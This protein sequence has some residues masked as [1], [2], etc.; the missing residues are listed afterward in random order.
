VVGGTRLVCGEY[1]RTEKATIY[2][3]PPKPVPIY[4]AAAGPVVAKLAGERG[5]GLICTS[6]KDP[7]PYRETLLPNLEVGLAKAGRTDESIERMIEMKVSFDTDCARAL[8]DTHY[9]G[10]LALEPEEKLNVED[11]IEM[12]RLADAL[13]VER[14]ASR[15]LVSSDGEEHVEQ[16]RPYVEM[17]FTH[18]VFHART[19]SAALPE[20]LCRASATLATAT[21]RLTVNWHSTCSVKCA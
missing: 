19:R 15:W 10:A 18:P 20:T 21:V 12:E 9:W 4:I 8:S 3:K 13:S 16:I 1:Y 14:A 7:V 5:D 2:D 17:G 11:P 6:G